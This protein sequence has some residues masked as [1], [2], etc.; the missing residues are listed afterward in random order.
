MILQGRTFE[1][2][3]VTTIEQD[4]F[5]MRRLRT[6]GLMEMVA[7]F[8]PQKSNLNVFSETLL[9]QAFESGLLFEVLG[10]VLVEK[11][12]PWTRE[13]GIA[14]STFFRTITDNKDKST[15]YEGIGDI[16]VAFLI[17]AARL[18]RKDFPSSL[19]NP[20]RGSDTTI[21]LSGESTPSIL[22][23]GTDL[24]GSSRGSTSISTPA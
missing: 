21:S 5:A 3:I 6:M 10:A 18:L 20:D 16:L 14:N 7:S 2:A 13:T 17:D 19:E 24:S 8:D 22:A 12:V 4:A 1:V 11:D 23:T 9:L 15:L